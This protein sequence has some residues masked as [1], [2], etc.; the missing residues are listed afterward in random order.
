MTL[1]KRSRD[2]AYTRA[3]IKV[4]YSCN[5]RCLFCECEPL[6]KIAD[7]TL[8][9]VAGKVMLA[10]RQGCSMV[11]FSGG[12]P[13]VRRDLP[14][15]IAL[16]KRLGL[17]SGLITNGRALC[18]PGY[19][20]RL[21]AEGLGWVQLALHADSADVHNRLTGS[22]GFEESWRAL[23]LL[24]E[25]KVDL[26][27]N[28]VL[29]RLN[30]DRIRPLAER[31]LAFAPCLFKVS[32]IEPRQLEAARFDEVVP[33]LS[34][35]SA[36][37]LDLFA[38]FYN[39]A[40]RPEGFEVTAAGFPLCALPGYEDTSYDLRRHDL[41]EVAESFEHAFKRTEFLG[42]VKPERCSPCRLHDI[43]PGVFEEYLAG[44]GDGELRPE[45]GPVS[46]SFVYEPL[47]LHT[48]FDLAEC[49]I[50]AGSLTVDEPERKLLLA[51][52]GGVR[53]YRT[54]SGDFNPALI[55]TIKLELG[56]I[57]LDVSGKLF[58]EDFET[59]LAK[60]DPH[61]VC[62]ACP[63][64]DACPAV[65]V[66]RKENVFAA[67]EEVLKA[68]VAGLRGRVLDVGGGPLR[69]ARIFGDLISGGAIDYFVIE[70]EP[71]PSLLSFLKTHDR[72][73]HLYR[74]RVETY[75]S[76]PERFD[77]VLVM[78]SH[79]HFH[80]LKRVYRNIAAWLKPGGSLIVVDNTVYGLVRSKDL[81]E[82][83]KAEG[84]P[85]RFEHF[86]NHDSRQA[87]PYVLE[88]GLELVEHHPVARET[89]NQWWC[90]FR[91]P[92]AYGA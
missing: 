43:C 42:R 91:K 54:D 37:V 6:K 11:I 15:L 46:N 85:D 82:K 92:V 8:K 36:A 55:R 86:N 1:K 12:E 52:T 10:S 27:V 4:G 35:A 22:D 69:Y 41:A 56:Q 2:I 62:A 30:L 87:V 58:H 51:E 47:D 40:D 81:W 83:I 33:S 45:T 13:T 67:A 76:G 5:N 64:F 84:G 19:T 90:L 31:L 7:P 88:A 61:P 59:D 32:L 38:W 3:K 78:R 24:H 26:L 63:K 66:R 14:K 79:N 20:K 68:L 89:A 73:G 23:E 29:T 9:Q 39:R 48:G 28:C 25:C 75:R 65:Y 50:L 17:E 53:E 49:P 77:W 70:P 71:N 80:D 18:R 44:R 16:T 21:L 57:Y 72:L 34:D 74:G 60:L